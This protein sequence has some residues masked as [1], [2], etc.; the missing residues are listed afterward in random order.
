MQTKPNPANRMQKLLAT[1]EKKKKSTIGES[2]VSGTGVS[3]YKDPEGGN[4]ENTIEVQQGNHCVY[5]AAQFDM[6]S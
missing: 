4:I 3:L 2:T 1:Q 6:I 5:N